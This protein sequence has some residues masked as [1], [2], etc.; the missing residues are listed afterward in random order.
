[1]PPESALW[2]YKYITESSED[3]RVP[4]QLLTGLQ[5]AVFGLGNS[6]YGA[7]FNT[8]C[9][10]IYLCINLYVCVGGSAYI[11]TYEYMIYKESSA[12]VF[13]VECLIR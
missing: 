5:Y 4:K 8:V 11:R 3:C 7:R 9:M 12:G 1:M 10:F 6:S 13:S 2:F